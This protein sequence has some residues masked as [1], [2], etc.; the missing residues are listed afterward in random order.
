MKTIQAYSDMT[1]NARASALKG[2]V[3][4]FSKGQKTIAKILF[5]AES[6][7]DFEPGEKLNAF[8]QRVTGCE[9]R[10]EC[11]GVYEAVN[12]LRGMKS[13]KVVLTET[14]FDEVRGFA[15]V[16]ISGLISKQP[17]KVAKAVQIALSGAKDSVAQLKE[18]SGKAPKSPASKPAGDSAPL[19]NNEIFPDLSDLNVTTYQVPDSLVILN[20]PEILKRIVAEIQ[21]AESADDCEAFL[22]IFGQ[23]SAMASARKDSLETARAESAK[24]ARQSRRKAAATGQLELAAA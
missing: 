11:Q 10:R 23:L 13:G 22:S 18:L 2:E 1:R 8:A 17:E 5:A 4:S 24:P 7:G 16:C 6:A 20:H 3:A 15:L 21:G 9:L 12:V 19:E 14:Q